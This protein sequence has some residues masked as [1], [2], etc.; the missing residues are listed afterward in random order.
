MSVLVYLAIGVLLAMF[1]VKSEA[2]KLALPDLYA[3]YEDE[4]VAKGHERMERSTFDKAMIAGLLA[5]YA[6]FWPFILFKIVYKL[7]FG[8]GNGGNGGAGKMA[9]A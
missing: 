7:F 9:K 3:V 5:I 6:V 2:I 4:T 8:G 1:T